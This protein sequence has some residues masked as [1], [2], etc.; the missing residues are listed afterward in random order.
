MAYQ[1]VNIRKELKL[2]AKGE[3]TTIKPS[4]IAAIVL[5]MWDDK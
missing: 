4:D 2:L 5:L 1:K 3:P